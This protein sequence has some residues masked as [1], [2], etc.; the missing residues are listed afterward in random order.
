MPTLR[1]SRFSATPSTPPGNSRS[2][3][4]IT[5]GRPS[6]WAMPS[7]ASETM[8]ISSR[9]G[10]AENVAT[11]CS[12]APEISAEEIVNSVMAFRLP[13]RLSG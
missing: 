3:W 7:P 2:S 12:I 1:S 4:V 8:P 5:E 9:V 11:Y 6:T 13:A 10:S